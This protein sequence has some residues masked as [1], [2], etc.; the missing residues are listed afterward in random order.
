MVRAAQS[1]GNLVPLAGQGQSR[2]RIPQLQVEGAARL[3]DLGDQGMMLAHE[4]PADGQGLS[5]QSQ[6]GSVVA[7]PEVNGGQ[8]VEGS[9]VVGVLLTQQRSQ[10]FE[11]LAGQ[12]HRGPGSPGLVELDGLAGLVPQA[13]AT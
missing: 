11:G 1:P 12:R 2:T 7:G 9:R 5:E 10:R 4:L 8:G 13:P 6:G 3:Y